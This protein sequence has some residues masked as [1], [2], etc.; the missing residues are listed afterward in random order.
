[1]YALYR[2]LNFYFILFL[3]YVL[4]Y[5]ILAYGWLSVSHLWPYNSCSVVYVLYCMCYA[6]ND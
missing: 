5:Y 3:F 6:V 1:M 4:F 2:F